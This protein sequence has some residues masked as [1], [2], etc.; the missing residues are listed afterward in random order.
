MG[1]LRSVPPNKLA[2]FAV[3]PFVNRVDM[4]RD[5]A[6]I[7]FN[8]K[9][10]DVLGNNLIRQWYLKPTNTVVGD[11]TPTIPQMHTISS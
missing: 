10:V 9:W 1:R 5:A 2:R 8:T 3:T 7:Q 6:V 4:Y 11:L